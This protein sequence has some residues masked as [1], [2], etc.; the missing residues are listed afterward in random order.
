MAQERVLGVGAR[1]GVGGSLE[2]KDGGTAGV[3]EAREG[4]NTAMKGTG[5]GLPRQSR[6]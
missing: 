4:S 5:Q 1:V 3:C 2:E 6:G